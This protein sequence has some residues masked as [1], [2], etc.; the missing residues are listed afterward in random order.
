MVQIEADLLCTVDSFKD[1]LPALFSSARKDLA[2]W[3][4]QLQQWM[5]LNIL[6][7]ANELT[8]GKTRIGFLVHL[9][10]LS[11]MTLIAWLAH[12]EQHA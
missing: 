10:Y 11:T 2:Q 9:L 4:E 6:V 1:I 7:E 12:G 5:H 8:A 3:Y